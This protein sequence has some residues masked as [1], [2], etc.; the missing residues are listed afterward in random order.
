MN[1][2]LFG[3]QSC[4]STLIEL[5]IL[6]MALAVGLL[7]RA[8]WMQSAYVTSDSMQP[9][10]H[11]GDRLLVNKQIYKEHKP[12]RGDIVVLRADDE[13][14]TETMVKRIVGFPGDEVVIMDGRVFINR[15]Q[16]QEPYLKERQL[17]EPPRWWRIPAHQYFVMGDNRNRSEDSRDYGAVPL[18]KFVGKVVFMYYPFDRWGRV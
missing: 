6:V 17:P 4:V 2:L 9:T 14:G 8:T 5:A 11:A 15:R 18:R 10:L 16:L 12:K 13:D 1:S 7:V 3:K